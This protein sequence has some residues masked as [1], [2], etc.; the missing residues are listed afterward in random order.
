MEKEIQN[1]KRVNIYVY[2]ILM[3]VLFV[4]T[5]FV[6][7]VYL[8]PLLYV[9]IS[10]NVFSMDIIFEAILAVLAFI[11]MLF[12]KNSYV[13]TQENE[14]FISSLKYGWFYLIIGGFFGLIFMLPALNNVPG[15]INIGLLCF[16]IGIYEEFLLRGW[17]LNEFL[18]RYGN[19]KKGVWISIIT[20]GIIFGLVH[21]INIASN[22]LATTFTQVL[23]ASA[24]GIVFGFIYY[25]TRQEERLR[26]P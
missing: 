21:F 20:S 7:H 1:K 13:F 18:E 4:F 15:I 14:K 25:K 19:T 8:S 9:N 6:I 17:L 12:W 3:F 10:E 2:S 11:V 22:G 16:L 23:S 5:F 26:I 24:S